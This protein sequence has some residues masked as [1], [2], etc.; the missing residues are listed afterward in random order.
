MLTLLAEQ[1]EC[2]WDDTLPIEVKV[3][4]RDL[5]ALD[6]LLADPELLWPIVERFRREVLEDRRAV[7]TDGRPTI[8]MEAYTRMMVL[9]QRYRLS[10]SC[11][12]ATASGEDAAGS[13]LQPPD[14]ALVRRRDTSLCN[15]VAVRA[16]GG[17]AHRDAGT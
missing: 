7:L 15:T 3:L 9:T 6:V 13:R 1:P 12:R 8:A 10:R 17:P 16:L 4:P 2:L 11:G 5:A 14:R